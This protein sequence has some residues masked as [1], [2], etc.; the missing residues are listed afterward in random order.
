MMAHNGTDCRTVV[1]FQEVWWII[2][3]VICTKPLLTCCKM[4]GYTWFWTNCSF[5]GSIRNISR[6]T[7]S[8]EVGTRDDLSLVHWL[9]SQTPY[10]CSGHFGLSWW[11]NT[12]EVSKQSEW[13]RLIYIMA[14]SIW[15]I[16][17]DI[18]KQY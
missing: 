4:F 11:S 8:V 7:S 9:Q 16:A 17:W 15:T 1:T 12:D 3:Y 5:S 18:Y 13:Y 6:S 10:S 14:V 2:S